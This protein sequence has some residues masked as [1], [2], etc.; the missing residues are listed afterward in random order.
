MYNASDEILLTR[1]L[2]VAMGL[3]IQPRTNIVVDQET[4]NQINFESKIL[5]ANND[6]NKAVYISSDDILLEPANP[7]CTKLMERLFGYFIDGEVEVGNIPDMKV[8]YFDKENFGDDRK[9]RLTIKFD[10]GTRWIGNWYFNKIISYVEAIFAINGTFATKNLV[11]FDM[12][13][14]KE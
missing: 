2:L 14:N 10:D 7:K 1:D 9:Y 11:P 5:K 3:E 4:K 12:P 6:P 13:Q 8:Y